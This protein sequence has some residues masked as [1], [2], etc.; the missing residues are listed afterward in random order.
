MVSVL[1]CIS[2]RS[3]KSTFNRPAICSGEYFLA[4]SASTFARS[5]RFWT[6]LAGLRAGGAVVGQSMRGGGPIPPPPIDIAAQLPRHRRRRPTQDGCDGPDGLAPC[7]AERDLFSLRQRQTP[8][9]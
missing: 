6:S 8:T 1:T 5:S 3:G 2:G 7:P 9:L 4:R